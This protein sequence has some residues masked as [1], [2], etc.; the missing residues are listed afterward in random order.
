MKIVQ[1][2]NPMLHLY[3]EFEQ[4][5]LSKHLHPQGNLLL[6]ESRE[7]EENCTNL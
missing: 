5:P 1:K 3:H 2:Q 4:N 6:T 7:T